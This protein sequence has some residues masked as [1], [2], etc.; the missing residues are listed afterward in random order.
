MS[1]VDLQYTR[2]RH[3]A[4]RFPDKSIF[5]ALTILD[6]YILSFKNS[7][8]ITPAWICYQNGSI[9]SPLE[10]ANSAMASADFLVFFPQFF[11]CSNVSVGTNVGRTVKVESREGKFLKWFVASLA[12]A[13]SPFFLSSSFNFA[14]FALVKHLSGSGS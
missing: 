5:Q 3:L 4:Y 1:F 13:V 14:N 11:T 6:N 10:L 9:L 7:L 8:W 2:I 12:I